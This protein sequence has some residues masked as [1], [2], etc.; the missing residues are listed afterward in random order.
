MDIIE[1][2]K[3]Y[4]LQVYKRNNLVVSCASGKYIYDSEGKKYLDFFSGLSVCNLG[5]CHPHIV[6]AIKKQCEKFMHTSNLYYTSPQVQLSEKLISSSFPGKV[7]FSN[8]GA[9]ANECAIKIARKYGSASGRYEIVTFKNSFHGRTIATVTATGQEKF[10]KGFQPLLTG[11]KYARYNDINSVKKMITKKTAAIMVELV[12]GEGGVVVADKKFICE[13][14]KLCEKNKLLLIFDEIQTGLGR[15]GELFAYKRYGVVPDIMTLAKALG[16]GLPLGATVVA[17]EY[18]EV[19]GTGEHGSTFGGNPV[20]CAA[21]NEVLS[22]LDKKLLRNINTVGDY[23]I[24]QLKVLKSKHKII[25]DIRGVGLMVGME[26]KIKGAEI[27][28][29]C[30]QRGLLINCT[31]DTV[32]RFLPPLIIDKQDVDTAVKILDEVLQLC[33]C[34]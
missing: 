4:H 33:A 10:Q 28:E 3:N 23:F 22:L 5:H 18:A 20:C 34:R 1:K 2:E 11:F 27:V 16:G 13:L 12:Q 15:C 25:K 17:K 19:L 8:S 21:A 7:F 9:E 32:L 31:Q 6:A 14:K 24:E 30:Q 26:L 29:K